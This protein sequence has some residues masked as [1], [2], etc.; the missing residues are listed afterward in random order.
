M[1]KFKTLTVLGAGTAL[2]VAGFALAPAI[3][4]GGGWGKHA[5]HGGKRAFR[6]MERMDADGNGELTLEEV[7]AGRAKRFAKFDGNGD[8]TVDAA[9]LKSGIM[10]RM[11]RRAERRVTKMMR[12]LDANGDGQI[13]ESEFAAP[14]QKRFGWNDLNDDGKL[15]GDELPRR[16]RW[17][18]N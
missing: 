11:E 3:A 7:Q 16:G 10:A 14:A 4:A 5:G 1:S 15:S 12:R 13:S 18:R 17:K 8:G 6:M 9:E 2:I